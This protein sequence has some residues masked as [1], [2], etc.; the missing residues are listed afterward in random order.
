MPD[1][2]ARE[3]ANGLAVAYLRKPITLADAKAFI[4]GLSHLKSM[5][6]NPLTP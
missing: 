2:W 1:L 5:L 3:V 6:S 4:T